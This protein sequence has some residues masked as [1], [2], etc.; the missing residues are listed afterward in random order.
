MNA[1]G[2]HFQNL[3]QVHS[4]FPNTLYMYMYYHCTVSDFKLI[5]AGSQFV[6]NVFGT[7]QHISLFFLSLTHNTKPLGV[8]VSS[9]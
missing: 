8:A 2:H 1:G 9:E 7:H 4:D 3:L 5:P 6:Y